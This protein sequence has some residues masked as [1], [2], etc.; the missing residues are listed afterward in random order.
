MY[1]GRV[2]CEI[3]LGAHKV[4]GA[5]AIEINESIHE[6]IWT[7]KLTMP[8][9][10][11]IRKDRAKVRE[12]LET[13]IK[14]GDPV[15]VAYGYDGENKLQFEGFIKNI[16]HVVPLEIECENAAYLCRTVLIETVFNGSL[17]NLLQLLITS[18]NDDKNAGLK[19]G[20]NIPDI[21][22]Q[23][24]EAKSKTALWV[25]QELAD[26]YDMLAI[27]FKG[28]VLNCHL[29][30][31]TPSSEKV[32]YVIGKNTADNSDLKYNDTPADVRVVYETKDK[33][34]KV[35]KKEFGS[36]TAE[37]V[38]TKKLTGVFADETLKNMAEQEIQRTAYAGFEGSI[39]AFFIPESDIPVVANISH[40]E[41][42]NR[43]GNYLV[44]SQVKTMDTSEGI[45][46]KLNI[47]FKLPR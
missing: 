18:V 9:Y 17:K 20:S 46:K 25:L 32:N 36:N 33:K 1:L 10:V 7:C 23:N 24:F 12:P 39:K 45:M 6:L 35:V 19:L 41:F 28:N 14:I 38:I 34:G 40:P 11:V 22:L 42:E 27:Y 31:L 15:S 3:G 43:K 47:D 29:K 5:N 26:Q 2:S 13:K 30:Y 37:K 21:S 8:N 4:L 44:G 16:N